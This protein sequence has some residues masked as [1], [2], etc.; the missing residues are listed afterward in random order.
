MNEQ[1]WVLTKLN[2]KTFVIPDP[3]NII[4]LKKAKTIPTRTAGCEVS[5]ELK[6][7]GACRHFLSVDDETFFFFVLMF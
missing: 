6:L 2:F 5:R 3:W 4:F 7:R 1:N